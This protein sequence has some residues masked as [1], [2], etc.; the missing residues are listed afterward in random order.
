MHPLPRRVAWIAACVALLSLLT[1]STSAFGDGT[2]ITTVAGAE[3][4]VLGS[5]QATQVTLDEPEDVAVLGSGNN[6]NVYVIDQDNCLVKKIV[7]TTGVIST[8]V[9]VPGTCASH[10]R[11]TAVT[12]PWA[13]G[14]VTALAATHDGKLLIGE[15]TTLSAGRVQLYD[16]A[17]AG[18]PTLKTVA[19]STTDGSETCGTVP[20]TTSA[21]V[22]ATSAALCNIFG[23]AG[24]PSTDGRYLIVSRST[25]FVSEVFEVVSG[26]LKR[27][28]TGSGACGT[29]ALT[30]CF[31]LARDALYTGSGN[32]FVVS[33]SGKKTITKF[34]TS[35]QT[36]APVKVAGGG[37]SDPGDGGTA[38]AAA[39]RGP[40][41][42]TP[43]YDGGYYIADSDPSGTSCRVR[44]VAGFL[45]TS[46]IST[47]A[48]T[49]SCVSLDGSRTDGVPATQSRTVWPIG[50]ALYPGGLLIGESAGRTNPDG[51]ALTGNGRVRQ[52][53]RTTLLSTVP[54]VT[55]AQQLSFSMATLEPGA[56]IVC[57]WGNPVGPIQIDPCGNPQSLPAPPLGTI[58]EGG[59][60]FSFNMKNSPTDPS[61]PAV[62]WFEDL[63]QPAAF[64]LTAP[65]AGATNLEAQ[66][67]FSWQASSDAHGLD[68]YELW[69][70]GTK[71]V[72]TGSA[73]TAKAAVPLSEGEHNWHVTAT[74]V[75]GNVR[76]S[77]TRKFSSTSPPSASFTVSPNPVLAGRTV[78]FDGSGSSDANGAIARYDWDLDGDGT[79][80]TDGGSSPT[81]SRTYESPQT[82]NVSLRVT[83]GV[84][85]TA[86]ATQELKVNATTVTSGLVGVTINNGAQY[87]RTPDVVIT[88][89]FPSTI[90]G[91]LFSN[92]GGF[93]APALFAPQR[94]TKWKLDSSGPERLPKIVYVRFQTGPFSSETHTDDIILDETPPKVDQASVIP[95][96][97]TAAAVSAA[98]KARKWSIKV[99]ATDSNSGVAFVQ[100]TA[101]KKKPG[102]LIA[103]KRK[104]AAK[105]MAR[106]KYI[107]ARDKAGNFSPWRTA[108]RR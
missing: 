105:S 49:G 64:A 88:A 22:T 101:S 11:A 29:T 40:V 44:K 83:D 4:A 9:G 47:V 69:I 30:H 41:G 42:L 6:T 65:A 80:E 26:N 81:T 5:D 21:T 34:D 24:H 58:E 37:A 72:D 92:D 87:T 15:R 74:D 89:T 43:T 8:A 73:T 76:T 19:G 31:S 71:N 16:P 25:T 86:T 13:L 93:L 45:A 108:K 85:L 98:A 100:V 78:A 51:S 60:S 12:G 99:K 48:G 14:V 79:F 2:Y 77:E 27:V 107:R 28:A 96:A 46:T 95:A 1:W 97:G 54:A 90:T 67:S 106:P 82:L 62:F 61:A 59:H 52:V 53:D 38:T 70:D 17:G 35:D 91:M 18:G 10:G 84:G 94:E 75:A 20:S 104:L 55:N 23:L 7:L 50:L 66:P 3:T 102:K 36:L 32:T 33:D 56:P 63:T 103:Y 68:H 39:L 57:N